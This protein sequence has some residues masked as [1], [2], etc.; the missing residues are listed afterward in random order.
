[1]KTIILRGSANSLRNIAVIENTAN[2][3][4]H[5]RLFTDNHESIQSLLDHIAFKETVQ[6]IFVNGMFYYS[7]R[8]DNHSSVLVARY[9][10]QFRDMQEGEEK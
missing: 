10:P 8:D 2:D 3:V 1:M 7:C 4:F 9:A 5:V 6:E